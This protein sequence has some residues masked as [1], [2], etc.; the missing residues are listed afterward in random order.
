MGAKFQGS[1]QSCKNIFFADSY[2]GVMYI[3]DSGTDSSLRPL[4]FEMS[5]ESEKCEFVNLGVFAYIFLAHK[6]CYGT[7]IQTRSRKV[8]AGDRVHLMFF[9]GKQGGRSGLSCPSL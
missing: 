2:T 5:H 1:S 6:K 9:G 3:N 7:I 8:P 4:T